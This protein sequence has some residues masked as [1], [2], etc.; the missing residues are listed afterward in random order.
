[1]TIPSQFLEELRARVGLA[2]VVGRRVALTRKGREHTGLCPFHKEKTPSFTVNEEKG[3]YHCF[4]CAAHGGAIDF[5]MNMDNLSFPEAVERLAAE[6]GMTVPSDTPEEKERE[7]QRQSLF[8]VTEAAAV[9]FEKN[10]RMPE[11]KAALDYLGARGLDDGVIAHFRIG[12]AADSRGALKG[13]LARQGISEDHLIAGGLLVR[14]EDEQ[15]RPYDR[16][17]RRVIFPIGDRRGRVIAFGGRILGEGEPKYLNSPETPLF[18]KGRTLYGLAQATAAARKTGEVIVTEGYMDVIALHRAGFENVVAPLGTALTEEQIAALWRLARQPILCFDGDAAGQRAATRAAE[19]ALPILKSGHGLRFATLP[20]GEDPDSLIGS[21]G[22][23]ALARILAAALPLSDAI[24]HTETWGRT[25]IGAE[26]RAALERRLGEHCERIGDPAL[27]SAFRQGFRDRVWR[28]TRARGRDDGATPDTPVQRLAQAGVPTP[29]DGLDLAERTML[30]VVLNHTELFDEV[31]EQLGSHGFSDPVMDALRQAL[32]SSLTD[33][34]D[35][36]RRG[37]G[38]DL[39]ER[40]H[41][42]AMETLLGDPLIR[43]NRKVAPRAPTGEAREVWEESLAMAR[44]L[45]LAAEKARV[46]RDLE[47][48]SGEEAWERSRSLIRAGLADDAA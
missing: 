36:D 13:A 7:R 38:E 48:E 23:Q 37:L 42:A 45:A 26:E 3:F 19:R 9:F 44:G 31:G 5:L 22:P 18:H 27:K 29:V 16:F 28:L 8:E 10:L 6:A 14:P 40:G 17:R 1:M 24:W 20:A 47:G 30:A 32:V 33:R 41:G 4:G 15:R 2:E 21:M 25:A 35:R 39:V 43:G 46:E 34:S 12:F 11:G